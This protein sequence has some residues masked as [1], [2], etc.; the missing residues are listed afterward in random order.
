LQKTGE[1]IVEVMV[2]GENPPDKSRETFILD[3]GDY[4]QPTEK[5]SAGTPSFLPPMPESAPRNRLGLAQWL[6]DGENP[7]TARVTV[8]R[9][10]A[11]FFGIGIVKT[12]EDFGVQGELPKHPELIDW[13]AVEFVESGWDTKHLIRLIVTSSTY[14]QS[15]EFTPEKLDRD[16]ENRLV[17]RGA[18]ARL[19]SML[20]RDQALAVAGL[21]KDDIGGH[22]VYPYQPDGL[23]KDFSFGK[24]SYPH[25]EEKDQLY[26]RSLYT[27][28]RRTSAPPNMFD[29]S[30]RQV[31]T[32][33]PSTTNTPLH[34]LTLL[35]DETYVEAARALAGRMMK[36]GGDNTDDRL[37]FAFQLSTGRMPDDR[38]HQLLMN[39]YERS[40]NEFRSFEN[41]AAEYAGVETSEA[42]VELAAL[43]RMAQVI[44]N[45]DETLNRP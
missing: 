44:L 34:A 31:C 8:N 28:W 40:L 18:R 45:L 39:G 33:K 9:L 6:V 26:R 23:W 43:T 37:D 1:S 21:L 19:P 42:V 13:L 7:L 14:R 3:R 22:P 36:E 25:Q 35:N 27:F 17:G 20:L 2:M 38:E 11:Q 4:Q 15:S 16:P 29:S 32:V 5:V 10:W 30:S 12:S 24:I 41:E